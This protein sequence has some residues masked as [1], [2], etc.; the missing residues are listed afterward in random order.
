MADAA[1]LCPSFY[2]ADVVHNPTGFEAWRAG[3][4]D[5]VI[6]WLQTRRDGRRLRLGGRETPHAE[7]GRAAPEPPMGALT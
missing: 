5:K 1:V 3:V 4:R 2:R 7:G 6:H